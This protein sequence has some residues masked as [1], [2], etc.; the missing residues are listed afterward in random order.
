MTAAAAGIGLAVAKTFAANGDRVHICDVDE[1]ALTRFS[2]ENS[3]ITATVCDVSDRSAVEA[4]VSSAVD[5]LGGIDVLINNAGISGPTSS[6]EDMDPE[7]WDAVLAVNLTGTFNVTR[8]SI[9]FLR[10]SDA[11]VVIIMSSVGGRF[12][13]PQRSPYA[14]TKRGLIALTETLAIELGGHGIRVNAIAPGAVAGDRIQ[15]VLKS[16]AQSTGQ[17]L[18]EVTADAMSIQS[19]KRFVDPD[20]IAALAVFLASDSAR[21]ITGQTIPIDNGSTA[22]E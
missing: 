14:V 11:G 2:H 16:R 1:Q 7:Q 18:E 10:R 12:G 4:F 19:I 6:V 20:D 15:R 5:V 3:A 13:Y 21:S 8:L 22:A 9:P 17:S